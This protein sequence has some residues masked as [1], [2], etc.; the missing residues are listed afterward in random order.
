V[1]DV[2]GLFAPLGSDSRWANPL[3]HVSWLILH[4]ERAALAV[5]WAA[6]EK[7]LVRGMFLLTGE[8]SLL[9]GF[10][11]IVAPRFIV[12]LAPPFDAITTSARGDACLGRV[13]SIIAD[14]ARQSREITAELRN[15]GFD[16]GGP[17]GHLGDGH[18]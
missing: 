7:A 3:V 4:H 11:T 6:I 8:L 1:R 12:W 5:A 16:M 18:R 13:L 9:S 14:A 2:V 17:V 10:F 15:L